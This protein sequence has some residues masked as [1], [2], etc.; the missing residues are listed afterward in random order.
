[1]AELSTLERALCSQE[2]PDF[3]SSNIPQGSNNTSSS[4]STITTTSSTT[5]TTTGVQTDSPVLK[6]VRPNNDSS[7]SSLDKLGSDCSDSLSLPVEPGQRTGCMEDIV[8]QSDRAPDAP[9]PD[10]VFCES[11]S[12]TVEPQ[13]TSSSLRQERNLNK[14]DSNDSGLHSDVIST[15]DSQFTISSSDSIQLLSNSALPSPLLSPSMDEVV[16][17]CMEQAGNAETSADDNHRSCEEGLNSCDQG[18]DTECS[19]SMECAVAEKS[20]VDSCQTVCGSAAAGK[21]E[22]DDDDEEENFYTP[23]SGV[24]PLHQP[25]SESAAV[26]VPEL[27]ASQVKSVAELL[28]VSH[29][30]ADT[31]S[32]SHSQGDA[33]HEQTESVNKYTGDAEGR[34]DSGRTNPSG[35]DDG[36]D[37]K[38]NCGQRVADLTMSSCSAEDVSHLPARRLRGVLQKV[39]AI[40]APDESE[41]VEAHA[42]GSGGS[43][44]SDSPL[45]DATLTDLTPQAHLDAMLTGSADLNLTAHNTPHVHLP[46]RDDTSL[47]LPSQTSDC[48]SVSRCDT[49]NGACTLKASCDIEPQNQNIPSETGCVSHAGATNLDANCTENAGGCD[50]SAEMNRCDRCT[51]TPHSA[52]NNDQSSKIHHHHHHHRRQHSN[53]STASSASSL[54]PHRTPKGTTN[55]KQDKS[56]KRDDKTESSKAHRSAAANSN[57][58]TQT[59]NLQSVEKSQQV[60]GGSKKSL[61]GKTSKT[62]HKTQTH[63]CQGLKSQRDAA[64]S[65]ARLK[66][67]ADN[68]SDCSSHSQ[69][70]AK[71]RKKKEK[72]L[73]P[74]VM[75]T[76][77]GSSCEGSSSTSDCESDQDR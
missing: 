8:C 66:Q 2:E 31:G 12:V 52:I 69:H 44:L 20:A 50:T 67:Y 70:D 19:N 36:D 30:S 49:D 62:S 9:S 65:E 25:S 10:A 16:E 24:S 21:E 56:K 3:L 22:D 72:K 28:T 74:N 71:G 39:Q 29:S 54:S 17:L 26:K 32:A 33:V 27:A 38:E 37:N 11:E 55:K 63:K 64:G 59:G 48:A 13:N 61:G 41:T 23:S 46:P 14:S 68:W 75:E 57:S 35:F 60:G 6:K 5:T 77:S 76:S 7:C 73:A 45:T 4:S 43:D 51:Q 15:S 47:A 53:P 58:T 18:K 1:M 34:S 40:F 42:M